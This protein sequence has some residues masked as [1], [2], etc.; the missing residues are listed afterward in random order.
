MQDAVGVDV[1]GYFDLRLAAAGRRDVV[2]LEL[3]DRAVLVR[4]RALALQDVDFD[5]RL[6]VGGGRE[7]LRF[8]RRNRR[9][10]L[11]EARHHA[12]HRLDA[13]AQGRYVE[14]QHVF[15]FARQHAALNRGTHGHH[16]VGVDALARLLTEELFHFF[17]DAR[18]P[19][20]TT[21]EDHLVDIGRL[22]AR[23][24]E[25]LFHRLHRAA[26]EAVGELLELRAAQLHHQVLRPRGRG[27][28][29]RQVD[30]GLRRR[31]QLHLRLL[32]RLFQALERHRVVA[33]VE[34]V[35]LG[36]KL[37]G[38]EIDDHLVEVIAAE[39][40]IAVGAQ[41]FEDALAQLQD[42]DIER[43]AAQVIDGDLMVNVVFVEP[44]GEGRRRRLVDDALDVEARDGARL[45]GGLALGVVEVR[46]HRD[47][48]L[49]NGL[50]EVVFRRLLHFLKHHRRDF[51]RRVRPVADFH[52]HRVVRPR[53]Q[54]VGYVFAL[55]GYFRERAPHK[56]LNAGNGI[57]RVR[58]GLALGGVAYFTL[59]VAI[60]EERDNRRRSTPAFGVRDYNRLVAFH[61]G[62]ARVGGAEVDSNDFAHLGEIFRREV[63]GVY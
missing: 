59:A 2:E 1:E 38:E 25:R 13:E 47:Y 39:V 31:R 15:D 7:R 21:H 26:D 46:R 62:H 40:G 60:V 48:G 50:A 9:V 55:L 24:A 41:H 12:A 43:T 52:R 18:N 53:R 33:Q 20:R 27:G 42:R 3:R 37:V 36:L 35:V 57:L 30:F 29:V 10:R 22:E 54:V 11:D 6:V 23:V 45:L 56:P 63:R 49:R 19:R 58:N 32:R 8:L 44:V 28:D 51:L 61:D 14:Q 16:F 4:Q 5:A 17:L 34:A